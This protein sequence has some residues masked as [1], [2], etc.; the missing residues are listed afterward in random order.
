ISSKISIYMWIDYFAGTTAD[1]QRATSDSMKRKLKPDANFDVFERYSHL[2]ARNV[3]ARP[4]SIIA[5]LIRY[6][7]AASGRWLFTYLWFSDA[8]AAPRPI[9]TLKGTTAD[10]Q[11]ATSD[12]MKQKA[13]NAT[14]RAVFNNVSIDY[15]Y[16]SN[17]PSFE[18]IMDI[19]VFGFE[20]SNAYSGNSALQGSTSQCAQ[21][22]TTTFEMTME[23][24]T[25]EKKLKL[26][27]DALF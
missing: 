10:A 25:M 23:W 15:G 26:C 13:Q 16:V 17:V 21:L 6:E 9:A 3:S 8:N 7:T 4:I 27:L 5:F 2:C 22:N 24:Q 14:A 12:S 11:R 20:Y 1:A 19:S 18:P